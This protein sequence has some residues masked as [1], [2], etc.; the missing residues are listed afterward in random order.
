MIIKPK[1][2]SGIFSR[3]LFRFCGIFFGALLLVSCNNHF[4]EI[5]KAKTDLE[6]QHA[7]IYS[8][9]EQLTL[10]CDEDKDSV[11]SEKVFDIAS[12]IMSIIEGDSIKSALDDL[13]TELIRDD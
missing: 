4:D 5:N 8:Y 9:A 2:S 3:P 13:A 11:S 6:Q 12:E 1:I 10:L 7:K